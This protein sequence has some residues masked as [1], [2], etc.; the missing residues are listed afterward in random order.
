MIGIIIERNQIT[1]FRNRRELLGRVLG[2]SKNERNK[3]AQNVLNVYG[4]VM[5]RSSVRRLT[6]FERE[7]INEIRKRE[8]F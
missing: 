7:S 8:D 3:M 1:D 2:P 5:P 4:N 6:A